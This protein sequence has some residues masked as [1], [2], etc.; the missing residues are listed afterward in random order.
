MS[1]LRVATACRCLHRGIPLR[2]RE[3]AARIIRGYALPP[4]LVLQTWRCPRCK[5][6]V[7]LRL[8]DLHLAT[9]L[10]ASGGE[11]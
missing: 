3:D 5:Q 6:V 11:R 7:E 8:A 4:D 1:D 9:D 10:A 2:V